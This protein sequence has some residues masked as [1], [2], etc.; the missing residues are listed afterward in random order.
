MKPRRFQR[1]ILF[2]V[3]VLFGR[4]VFADA[5]I[6]AFVA[7][8]DMGCGCSSQQKVANRMIEWRKNHPYNIVLTLGDNIYGDWRK[9]GGYRELF[10]QRF[11]RYY[12]PLMNQGVE[13]YA[14][15]G[16]HDLETSYG[17]HEILD[18]ARFH[19]LRKEG[20][21][22]FTP[23]KQVNGKPLITFIALNS[24]P[25]IG[26][27]GDSAQVEWLNPELSQSKALWKVVYFH[28]PIY[29]PP[30]GHESELLLR[31][32]MEQSFKISGVRL[33]LSGHNHF[34]ARSKP[35]NGITYIV[36]GGG[37]QSLY[38]PGRDPF[39]AIASKTNHFF[40]AEV[41]ANRIDFLAVPVSGQPI[42]SG[43]IPLR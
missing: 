42:D 14:A 20:Y 31:K 26:K 36:S 17:I 41:Y 39:T 8:G 29:T 15:L 10:A 19:I 16:N 38:T 24:L 18:K 34:Y 2:L 27:Q 1:I 13:F 4:F 11:D 35:L 43:T 9:S 5:P 25:L 37:G 28:H 32:R 7:V 23:D 33:V 6:L 40:Y 21:Y 3:F 12:Y 30:G 22:S